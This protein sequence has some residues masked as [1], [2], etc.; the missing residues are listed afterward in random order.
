MT[1]KLRKRLEALWLHNTN[2]VDGPPRKDLSK[3]RYVPKAFTNGRPG[4]GA[5]D[6]LEGRFLK[7]NE[8]ERIPVETL[9]NESITVH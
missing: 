5:Y 2:P 1:K 3:L 9:I 6:Q 8:V 7:D 4:W